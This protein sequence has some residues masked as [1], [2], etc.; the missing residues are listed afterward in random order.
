M[1]SPWLLLDVSFLA[2]RAFYTTG[3]L[4]HRGIMT[5]IIYGLMRDIAIFKDQ[6]RT[7]NVAFCFDSKHSLRKKLYPGYKGDR[8]K[9]KSK[10]ELKALREVR[11]QLKKLRRE[12]LSQ[13]GFRNLF[14]QKGYEADDLI[15]KICY[16]HFRD[17]SMQFIIISSDS[18]LYQLVSSTVS[19]WN[20][21]KRK[22][23]TPQSLFKEHGIKRWSWAM[24]RA[25][26]G[27]KDNIK[28]VKGVGV[29]TACKYLQGNASERIEKLVKE[30]EL[31][32]QMNQQLTT[33]PFHGVRSC[34]L[35]HDSLSRKRWLEFVK[36]L[37]MRSLKKYMPMSTKAR[38]HI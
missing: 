1:K 3:K 14:L 24:A 27:N 6:F 4:S 12:Y 2:Y 21:I 33:L 35:V 28:G 26:A 25:I 23:T 38:R 13:I 15:A 16:D 7:D 34:R 10:K 9:G 18:D 19:I 5:G 30:N 22:R 29:K 31:L 8:N 37:G 36:E 17:K 32:I 20:P 11:V